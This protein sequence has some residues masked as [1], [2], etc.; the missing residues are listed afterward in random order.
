[1]RTVLSWRAGGNG[2]SGRRLPWLV[3]GVLAG[4]LV[5]PP[6]ARPAQIR[7][8]DLDNRMVD[9]LQAALGAKAT[10]FVF[11]STECPIS[12]RYAPEVQRLSKSFASRGIRFQLIYPNPSDTPQMI[13]DHL[14]SF[15]YPMEALRDSEHVLA[16]FVHAT[17][18]PQAVVLAGARVV[19]R[20][21]I[22][23]RYVDVG[24]ERPQP[25]ERDLEN[26]LTAVL[27]GR[28]V[29]RPATEPIGCFIADSLR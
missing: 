29:G 15:A 24:L 11:I 16:R 12:N 13:R 25:T 3:A 19:Y 6:A 5:G 21:R 7:L 18:T 9:P 22:D 20:G 8:L 4:M 2:M 1:M 26:A 17:V 10:V 27:A 14:R 28:P 23:D